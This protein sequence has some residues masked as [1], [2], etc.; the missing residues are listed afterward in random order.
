MLATNASLKGYGVEWLE[1][2]LRN[3]WWILGLATA[4]S[5]GSLLALPFI[6]ISLPHDYFLHNQRK[7][8][9]HKG[10]HPLL[11]YTVLVLKN[12]FGV[13]L[14][15]LGGVLLVLPGQ[16]LLTMLVGLIVMDLPG[17]Y[18]LMRWL[19]DHG[20]VLDAL[21][22]LRVRRGR[23]PLERPPHEAGNHP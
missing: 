20:K 11:G 1:L 16:G 19:V 18:R 12:L 21:N 22:W 6:V 4:V 2:F 7:R 15:L 17:K 14:L 23:K 5:I 10:A 13:V 3:N 8:V 9:L